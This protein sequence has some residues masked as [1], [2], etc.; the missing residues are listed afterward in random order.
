MTKYSR[1]AP[2]V[3]RAEILGA[4]VRVAAHVGYNRMTRQQIAAAA[5]CSAPTVQYYFTTMEA[6]RRAVMRHAVRSE[7]LPVIAQGLVAGD[8]QAKRAPAD[9]QRV[10]LESFA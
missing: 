7:L 4:A 10:A 9:L 8:R 5:G 2:D 1:K 6:L 3:R